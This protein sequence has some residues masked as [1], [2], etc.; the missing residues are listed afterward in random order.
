MLI[1]CV[2]PKTARIALWRFFTPCWC[3]AIQKKPGCPTARLGR[4]SGLFVCLQHAAM[5]A[6]PGKFPI[7]ARLNANREKTKTLYLVPSCPQGN[8]APIAKTFGESALYK[9]KVTAA[10]MISNG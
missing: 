3:R 9:L 5:A 8:D 4:N 10:E 1:F 2:T 6:P 7:F